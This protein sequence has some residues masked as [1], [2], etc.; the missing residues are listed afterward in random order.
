MA[1]GVCCI[2]GKGPLPAHGGVSIY[3]INAKGAGM[4]HYPNRRREIV[5]A[6]DA[7]GRARDQEIDALSDDPFARS[8]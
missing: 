7:G 2:C 3:R 8:S 5:E 4:T 1:E 6:V